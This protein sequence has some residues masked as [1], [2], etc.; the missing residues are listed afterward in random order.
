[1]QSYILLS[2]IYGILP[3][4]IL[5]LSSYDYYYDY[6]NTKVFGD[7]KDGEVYDFIVGKLM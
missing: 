1:M 7:I 6:A 4:L 5:F 3:T 2:I